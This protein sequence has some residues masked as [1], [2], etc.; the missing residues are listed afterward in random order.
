MN[1]ADNINLFDDPGDADLSFIDAGNPWNNER[2]E[3]A[4]EE[5]DVAGFPVFVNEDEEEQKE[6]VEP[7]RPIVPP[8]PNA[9]TQL[10][11]TREQ[12][13]RSFNEAF[14]EVV[15]RVPRPNVPLPPA[16]IVRPIV[17]PVRGLIP[18]T[19]YFTIQFAG[20]HWLRVTQGNLGIWAGR[21]MDR[22]R[23][24][25]E[26]SDFSI[27]T[28]KTAAYQ[29]TVEDMIHGEIEE[30][31]EQW[32]PTRYMARNGDNLHLDIPHR[33]SIVDRYTNIVVS[34]RAERLANVVARTLN[35]DVSAEAFS[36]A[37][38][39]PNFIFKFGLDEHTALQGYGAIVTNSQ[40]IEVLDELA[41]RLLNQI[42][43]RMWPLPAPNNNLFTIPM[44]A[45]D[46]VGIFVFRGMEEDA[47]VIRPFMMSTSFKA[48]SM[49]QTGDVGVLWAKSRPGVVAGDWGPRIRIRDTFVGTTLF[50]DV[51]RDILA[52]WI[53][54]YT[55]G[56]LILEGIHL[57]G[58]NIHLRIYT[59]EEQGGVM[60]LL[61][62][63]EGFR[64]QTAENIF[65][66]FSVVVA[67]PDFMIPKKL[68]PFF[69]TKHVD[70]IPENAGE[71]RFHVTCRERWIL[72]WYYWSYE[73]EIP[74]QRRLL[75]QYNRLIRTR[76]KP[77][78]IEAWVSDVSLI[79]YE[80]EWL[81]QV[82]KKINPLLVLLEYSGE[83]F[84][85]NVQ[86][87]RT[88][89][90]IGIAPKTVLVVFT[91]HPTKNGDKEYHVEFSTSD[92]LPGLV[93]L[94]YNIRNLGVLTPKQYGSSAMEEE[95]EP[96]VG[97]KAKKNN[98]KGEQKFVQ[99]V[100]KVFH[101]IIEK[102]GEKPVTNKTITV[103]W[104]IETLSAG[105]RPAFCVCSYSKGY[106]D[107]RPRSMVWWDNGEDGNVMKTFIDFWEE[108]AIAHKW[109]I[110][111]WSYN[112]SRFDNC[113]LLPV[114][115][116]YRM[117]GSI[118]N[119]KSL[120]KVFDGGAYKISFYDFALTMGFGLART[121][122][123]LQ[124]DKKFMKDAKGLD[125][126]NF[127]RESV[128]KQ[129]MDII[130]YCDL[131]CQCLCACVEK[132]RDLF[133]GT[134]LPYKIPEVWISASSLAFNFLQR[135]FLPNQFEP[136]RQLQYNRENFWLN[137]WDKFITRGRNII[138]AGL[139]RD[140][141]ER[142][143]DSYFGGF[144]QV[145]ATEM[146]SGGFYYDINS[147]YPST[148]RKDVPVEWLKSLDNSKGRWNNW[149]SKMIDEDEDYYAI[150]F[151]LK[152]WSFTPLHTY[153]SIPVREKGGNY[154]FINGENGYVWGHHLKWIIKVEGAENFTFIVDS[155]EIFRVAP[156]FKRIVTEFYPMKQNADP[157]PK[158][159][160]A[161]L[162][163]NSLYGKTG[164]KEYGETNITRIMKGEN[165]MDWLQMFMTLDP[166][167]RGKLEDIEVYDRGTHFQV[168][169]T[170]TIT[171]YHPQ[172]FG[173]LKH[174]ASYVTS[175]ARLKLFK[176]IHDVKSRSGIIYYC[177]TDSI[178]T[179]IR[180]PERMLHQS[181][182]GKWKLENII[183]SARFW[184]PK[185]YVYETEDGKEFVKA[186]GIP[187]RCFKDDPK[188]VQQ[189]W[190]LPWHAGAHL[191]TRMGNTF[192]GKMGFSLN[193]P[194]MTR[195]VAPTFKNRR[196]FS[197]NG[198]Y[199]WGLAN[200]LEIIH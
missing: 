200:R 42:G 113:Y 91:Y 71:G 4:Y 165:G 23:V 143:G 158:R 116:G 90:Y 171:D 18:N 88:D 150:L 166:E 106:D 119:L 124:I 57:T 176:A 40:N 186:K 198:Q 1:P 22:P 134:G 56:N 142:V 77:G 26:H 175:K 111:F 182:L 185:T 11:A 66:R 97:K 172:H 127:T 121:A 69:Y 183:K 68:V 34:A 154:Y 62:V 173:A 65:N 50:S 58:F 195:T 46:P 89:T 33:T 76:G 100:T 70:Q 161:K 102:D 181:A 72:Q 99:R 126:T 103:Y 180:L 13:R 7:Q 87:P 19:H 29:R 51:L 12:H 118:G 194:E 24:M 98:K 16:R 133:D 52:F 122:T 44:I 101:P 187:A 14:M 96:I 20:N 193:K 84:L 27:I 136:D 67:H 107:R 145:F 170:K 156:L 199:S 28:H 112:G 30:E 54:Q 110:N 123:A 78:S 144:T 174:I 191:V 137:K 140:L 59:Q 35:F 168:I 53:A 73:G 132:F 151:H 8:P 63:G 109:N 179:N 146:T 64:T 160:F 3:D 83:G 74:K 38:Q 115:T 114:I 39:L 86:V 128:N 41:I 37:C 31:G 189:M 47:R 108:K 169:T 10:D 130:N 177:D 148:M 120:T 129:R 125:V 104:D 6:Y 60:S 163:L 75:G 196:N 81:Q 9:R 43:S 79:G 2:W 93:N 178:F 92:K 192:F 15:R 49:D 188:L 61:D 138:L 117:M 21:T 135:Y 95:E 159:E 25:G 139:H 164:Q 147:S 17:D 131:D 48:L 157:G 190:T 197:E 167:D 5:V 184:G 36:V 45:F 149:I 85:E 152:S 162:L 80:K 141:Y 82:I 153:P 105:E 55:D 32:L 155:M 94:I